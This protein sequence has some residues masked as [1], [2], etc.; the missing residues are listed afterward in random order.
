MLEWYS[1]PIS[2]KG[3]VYSRPS[4]SACVVRAQRSCGPPSRVGR[5]RVQ[6]WNARK[7][8]QNNLATIC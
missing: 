5:P 2:W 3:T 6:V 7:A 8:T 1:L 4:P